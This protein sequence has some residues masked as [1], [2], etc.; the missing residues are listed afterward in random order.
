[1]KI[2]NV[3]DTSD[4]IPYLAQWFQKKWGVP[5]EAHV[6]SME[7]ACE[8][9]TGIPAWYYILDDREKII[10][11]VGIIANEFHKRPDLTPNICALYVEEEFRGKGLAG[12]L[13]ESVYRHLAKYQIS[14]AYSL[15]TT[16]D[17]VER[18]GWEFF[19]LVKKF[20]VKAGEMYHKKIIENESG[21]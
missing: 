15:A 19:S 17:F 9:T 18:N 7:A 16:A 6:A 4:F 20:N 1:M 21:G 13:L 8:T 12:E 5:M 3:R 11:G 10:A 2:I 14:D